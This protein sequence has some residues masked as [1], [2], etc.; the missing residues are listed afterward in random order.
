MKKTKHN[1]AP[2][3]WLLLLPLYLFTLLLLPASCDDDDLDSQ[4]I[5][6][7]VTTEQ[8]DFDQWIY[9]NYTL[10]Y[11]IRL[12]YRLQDIESDYNYTLAPADYDKS[13][14]LAHI[15]KY[16][17]IEAYDEV[18]GSDFT[19]TYVP[20]ILHFVGSAAYNNNGTMVLGTAEG[21]M[22]VT[23][24][25]VN[26]LQID[27]DFLN[28][29]YFKTMHHEFAHILHQTKNYPTEFDQISAADYISGDWYTMADTAAHHRG[30]V[31]PYSMSEARE[32]IAEVTSEYITKTPDEWQAIIDDAGTAGAAIINR[33]LTIVRN[34]MQESWGIDL[35]NLRSVVQRRMDDIVAGNIN[36]TNL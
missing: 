3:A 9:K 34:Y 25:L 12:Y 4:S 30:F 13:I 19:R 10:P 8:T 32:D 7:D 5:F 16:A 2:R 21:G 33:K 1:K 14:Q 26:S 18:A 29:Y 36:L 22:K 20:K 27:R 6:D 31:T 15:V 35:D 23:L 11:N 17:W 28:T 24:Y